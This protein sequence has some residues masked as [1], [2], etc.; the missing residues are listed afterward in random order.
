MDEQEIS[1]EV[2]RGTLV[3]ALIGAAVTIIT[4]LLLPFPTAA[5][6]DMPLTTMPLL[7]RIGEQVIKGQVSPVTALDVTA[8]LGILAALACAMVAWLNGSRLA[9]FGLVAVGALGLAYVAGMS[10]PFV[11]PL[12]GVCGYAL[13]LIGGALGL[14]VTGDGKDKVEQQEKQYAE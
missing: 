11:G 5:T 12:A 8:F 9:L 10:I 13:I 1:R 3:I 7:Q 4:L 6:D 2:V 14:A